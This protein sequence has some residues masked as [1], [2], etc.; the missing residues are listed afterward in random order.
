MTL[1]GDPQLI[2]LDEPSTGLDPRSR[3]DLWRIVRDLVGSGVTIFLTTQHLAEAD[4]LADRI[5]LL[6]H[7]RLVL[8]RGTPPRWRVAV[9]QAGAYALELVTEVSVSTSPSYRQF[10]SK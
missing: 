1:V 2:F 10:L 7:G 8:T 9:Q 4:E 3:R 6:D 5:G